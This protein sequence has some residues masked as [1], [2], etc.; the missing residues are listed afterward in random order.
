MEDAKKIAQ[1]ISQEI[2]KRMAVLY[3]K[4][5]QR[6]IVDAVNGQFAD[7]FIEGATD[8]H[9]DILCLGS[10]KPA[11]DDKVLVLR[12]GNSGSNYL[13]VGPIEITPRAT[14]DAAGWDIVDDGHSK[15]YTMTISNSVAVTNGQRS[16][17][18]T[19]PVPTGRAYTDFRIFVS[20][21]GNFSG[22]ATPGS[23]SG[24]SG[25]WQ[26]NLGNEYSGGALTFAGKI[27]AVLYEIL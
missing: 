15:V 23:E 21:E 13:V 24:G 22:H 26:A 19:F 9:P 4:Q 8:A 1:I 20:W 10:Y 18:G 17:W 6:G 14:S 2:D 16:I 12:L 3:N 27:H 11:V 7:V 5:F 25:G